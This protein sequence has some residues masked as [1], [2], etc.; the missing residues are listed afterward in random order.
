MRVGDERFCSDAPFRM[1]TGSFRAKEPF[2]KYPLKF[3]GTGGYEKGFGESLTD[4]F[5]VV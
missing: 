1:A 2:I 5:W 3:A 4:V